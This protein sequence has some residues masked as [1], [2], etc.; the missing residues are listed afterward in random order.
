MSREHEGHYRGKHGPEAVLDPLLAEAV[1]K[2]AR[3]GTIA[4]ATAFKVAQET[5]AD[6]ARVG[7]TLDLLEI[8][9]VDCQLGLFGHSPEEKP[10]RP[11]ESVPPE[12][13][14]E[15]GAG[16]KEGYL[17]CV[18]AWAIAARRGMAK[19]AVSSAGETLGIKIRL[20]QLG[21]F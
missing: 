20:C 5:G 17:P 2:K 10:I 15:I 14:A 1:K 18:E 21:A 3:A 9:L 16:L 13:E 19:M 11:A 7:Q 12:L 6:P 4:C 8:R